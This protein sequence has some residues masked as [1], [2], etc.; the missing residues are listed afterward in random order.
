MWAKAQRLAAAAMIESG[1]SYEGDARDAG[2]SPEF[3]GSLSLPIRAAL[4]ASRVRGL[5]DWACPK[6]AL[7]VADEAIETAHKADSLDAMIRALDARLF[8]LMHVNEQSEVIK[9]GTSLIEAAE[10]AGDIV[11]ATRGRMNTGSTLNHLGMFEEARAMLER[12]LDDARARRI[13]VLEAFTLHNLGMTYARLGNLDD[14]ID[15]QRQAARI[16]DETSAARLRIQARVYETVFLV[17]R[18]AP[19]T[20]GLRSAGEVRLRRDAQPP[21]ALNRRRRGARARPA[22]AAGHRGRARSGARREPAPGGRTDRGMGGVHP[23][24]AHRSAPRLRRRKTKR[25]R[26]STWPSAGSSSAPGR[27]SAGP[28]RGVPLQERGGAPPRGPRP[29]A[30]RKDLAALRR[31]ARRAPPRRRGRENSRPR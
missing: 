31:D 11:L 6:E 18:G 26:C 2:R 16:A 10:S 5:I 13:R 25:T 27:S 17:W 12:A 19:A 22:R 1:R 29:G 4:L 28:P 7:D 3:A 9:V 15:Y 21:G 8:A 23:P 14:G 24:D 20:S 30:P